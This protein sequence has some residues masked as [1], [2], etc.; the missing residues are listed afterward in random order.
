MRHHQT[1]RQIRLPTLIGDELCNVVCDSATSLSLNTFKSVLLILSQP[2]KACESGPEPSDHHPRP[3]P[4]K[5]NERKVGRHSPASQPERYPPAY[6]ETITDRLL[7]LTSLRPF[8][9]A[10]G[11]EMTRRVRVPQTMFLGTCSPLPRHRSRAR[12]G[13]CQG[14]LSSAHASSIL[15]AS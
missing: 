9:G 15:A 5:H 7:Y 8:C 11:D 12:P 13:P 14:G 4:S 10:F 6:M 1:L 2:V 3:A